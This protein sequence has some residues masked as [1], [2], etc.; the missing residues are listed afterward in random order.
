MTARRVA[1]KRLAMDKGMLGR[2]FQYCSYRPIALY[3]YST[4][5]TTRKMWKEHNRTLKYPGQEALRMGPISSQVSLTLIVASSD[6]TGFPLQE[7]ILDAFICSRWHFKG[8]CHEWLLILVLWTARVAFYITSGPSL[9][10][11]LEMCGQQAATRCTALDVTVVSIPRS[12][13]IKSSRSNRINPKKMTIPIT[14]S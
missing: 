10:A 13:A 1:H 8:K 9:I 5:P 3:I 4:I 14:E 12:H 7:K 6:P 11:R 2:C